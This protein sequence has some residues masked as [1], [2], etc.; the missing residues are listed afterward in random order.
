MSTKSNSFCK[1]EKI[2]RNEID[3]L[4]AFAVV[5]VIINHFNQDVLPSGYLGVDIFFV[6]SGYVIT[7]SFSQR[8]SKHFREFICSF[9][10]RRIKRIV[11]ALIPFTC[12]SGILICMFNPLPRV[13]LI[14]GITS[15]FGLSNFYLIN[16]S[17][18]YFA[19]STLL[20]IFTHTWSLDVEE[21]FYLIFP[22]LIWFTGFGQKKL[23]SFK[24]LFFTSI[25][26]SFISLIFYIQ[27]YQSNQIYA[28]FL[29]PTR[30]W[31][32]GMG[33]IT[34]LIFK[35]KSYLNL[36]INSLSSLV[37]F[38]LIICVL[39]LPISASMVATIL[40]VFLTSLLIFLLREGTTIHKFL[41]N[42]FVLHIGK[43]SYS[44]Y[45]WHWT[46]LCI[47]RWTIGI[48]LWSV[49]IQISIIYLCA[50]A[51]YKWIEIPFR[52]NKWSLKK[53]KTIV[54]GGFVLFISAIWLTLLGKSFKNKIFLGD[55]NSARESPYYSLT[56]DEEFC[57]KEYKTYSDN[58]FKDLQSAECFIK[59]KENVKTLFFLGDSHNLALLSGAEMI[60]KELN[61][62]LYYYRLGIFPGFKGEE[63]I[64]AKERKIVSKE[65]LS[66][67]S[68]GD[69][70]FITLRMPSRFLE[71]NSKKNNQTNEYFE[72]WLTAIE[73]LTNNLKK[74]QAQLFLTTPLPEFPKAQFKMCR[75]QNNQWF[76]KL[77]TK[78]CKYSLKYF[79]SRNG[80]YIN[81]IDKLNKKSAKHSNLYLFDALNVACQNS[82]CNFSKNDQ[83]IFKDHNHLSDE[84]IRNVY[85]PKLLRFISINNN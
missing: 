30:F 68:K 2:Y 26:F 50:L 45:L 12:I 14:T 29:M 41:I 77:N 23:N 42:R 84:F 66:K 5:I 83:L 38:I 59:G 10:E 21:Q 31:E 65:L 8:V 57:P 32:M 54:K 4:R 73:E 9:F 15:L 43:I 11:P 51:S 22:F 46:V 6:I 13:S 1:T 44:L 39:F 25:F 64:F 47:S 36:K 24:N 74:K 53:W 18:D 3:G 67:I 49:P 72:K 20:N 33:C 56:D 16:I 61:S 82:M 78:D 37:I 40:I 80:K 35:N 75:G 19:D 63:K 58:D 17:T 69:K 85:A 34:F 27:I 71:D 81:L 76:N 28:Y 7:S 70:L 62:N 79:S 60:S 48:H 52:N 55:L